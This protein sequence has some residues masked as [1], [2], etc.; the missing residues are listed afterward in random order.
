MSKEFRA[1]LGPTGLLY[2]LTKYTNRAHQCFVTSLEIGIDI[3]Q[4]R[5][6]YSAVLEEEVV[7]QEGSHSRR[8]TTSSG[9]VISHNV[10]EST[11]LI[12]QYITSKTQAHPQ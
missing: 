12:Y 6:L 3:R 8:L 11:V 4:N 5:S 9:A 2:F 10:V 7:A 1:R